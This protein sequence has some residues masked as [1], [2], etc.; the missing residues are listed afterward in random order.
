MSA[1][2]TP[3]SDISFVE[4]MPAVLTF[5]GWTV[6]S[7]SGV[8]DGADDGKR[9]ADA[10]LERAVLNQVA[11]LKRD[12]QVRQRGPFVVERSVDERRQARRINRR[13]AIVDL[14]GERVLIIED[15]RVRGRAS[16]PPFQP[17][18]FE[19]GVS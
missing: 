2:S 14:H 8:A 18:H 11:I 1:S 9:N 10:F 17:F 4:G 6:Q 19:N 16:Q 15:W 13:L 7:P 5:S 12:A 3:K